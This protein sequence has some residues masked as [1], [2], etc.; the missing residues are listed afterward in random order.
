MKITYFRIENFRNIR[1]AEC[2]NPPDF[3]VICGGNGCGKS[4]LFTALMMAKER[5]GPYGN[6]T[7]DPRSVSAD[8]D[9]AT[10]S[11][12]FQ[13]SEKE[14]NFL[15]N[16]CGQLSRE[17][18][19]ITV[20]IN[21]SG[22]HSVSK[23]SQFMSTLLSH[24]STVIPP[25]LGFFDY[26]DAYRPMQK[27]QLTSFDSRVLSDDRVK[28]TFGAE[29]TQKYQL[30]KQYL[31]SL[32]LK[33]LQDLHK[34]YQEGNPVLNDSLQE[35]RTFFNDF[36]SPLK[37]VDVDISNSPFNFTIS[38]P[39]GYI[40]IDDLSSGEKEIFNIYI[41]FH[42]LKPQESIILF[43]EADAHLHPDLERRYLQILRKVSEGNQLWLTT[44][45]PE[46]MIAAGSE[47]LYTILK[48][49]L[50]NGGN[51]LVRVTENE[52]L[53]NA[54]SE[55]MGSRG[56]VSFNQRIIFI[57]G[58]EASADREIYEKLYPPGTFNVSFVPTGGSSTVQKTAERVNELL[59]ISTGFQQYF[60][61][62]DG[63]I[64]RAEPNPTKGR[65]LFKLPIYHVE[66]FLVD[67]N[68]ILE[69]TRTLLLSKCPY[70][71][72]DEIGS[73]LKNLLLLDQ[74]LKPYTRALLDAKLAK[75]A[76]KIEDAVFKG[77]G[78]EIKQA[79]IPQF[80]DVEAEAKELL[81]LAI[82]DDSW[83]VKCKGRDLLKAYCCQLGVKY[84]HF[85]NLLIDRMKTPPKPLAD[86]MAEILK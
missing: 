21:K 5:I 78:E 66:N 41:R 81:K 56:L 28:G 48:E 45:S 27:N 44:H 15:T 23:N 62:V 67:E 12:K 85:R 4:A 63:D 40:D 39:K 61:I 19:E 32:K 8:A 18:E 75:L 80:I 82:A 47:S 52:Q 37:F 65:R 60:S 68:Q 83:R 43:D 77:K 54:L 10:V 14:Q 49:P 74:H 64:E 50:N 53:H 13:L 71:S 69:C 76:K 26:I 86:I 57:E 59:A 24:Y 35:I 36:F 38:T 51:Q 1:L 42:H 33:D 58:E 79:A 9:E 16:R 46:M 34:S 20:R 7:F 11:I 6:F 72:A 70:R 31:T 55:V 84:E 17:E 2:S 22:Q 29:G 30:T 25:A 3:M 73:E